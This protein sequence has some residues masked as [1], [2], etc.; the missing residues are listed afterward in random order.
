MGN[1]GGIDLR[2]PALTTAQ[3]CRMF[4]IARTLVAGGL[5]LGRIRELLMQATSIA[6]EQTLEMV[7]DA[8]HLKYLFRANAGRVDL[9]RIELLLDDGSQAFPHTAAALAAYEADVGP[10]DSPENDGDDDDGDDDDED[11]D[12]DDDDDDDDDEE[13]GRL[14][15]LPESYV[16]IFQP[17][18]DEAVAWANSIARLDLEPLVRYISVAT[19]EHLRLTIDR[20][21][22][23]I[24]PLH[25]VATTGDPGDVARAQELL[26]KGR[27]ELLPKDLFSSR[28]PLKLPTAVFD[29]IFDAADAQ[30]Q[31]RFKLLESTWI[32]ARPR[33]AAL[34]K[35]AELEAML[36]KHANAPEHRDVYLIDEVLRIE[37]R[38]E[39]ERLGTTVSRLVLFAWSTRGS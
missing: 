11:E 1:P 14:V 4:P 5:P 30:K 15:T 33:I 17:T 38:G 26:G 19:G 34:R 39:A 7:V 3:R 32:A 18:H 36:S 6:P 21:K 22:V 23:R 20:G 9:I 8:W 10:P 28:Q 16:Q 31:S 24:E 25:F 13:G 35:A 29:E 27:D 2:W 37:M 12:E